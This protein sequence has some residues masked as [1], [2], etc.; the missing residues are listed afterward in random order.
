MQLFISQVLQYSIPS[1]PDV[2]MPYRARYY[3]RREC[4]GG[5]AVASGSL[6][7]AGGLRIMFTGQSGT[8]ILM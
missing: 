3:L 1:S 4:A 2:V 5:F 6:R 7:I 8:V